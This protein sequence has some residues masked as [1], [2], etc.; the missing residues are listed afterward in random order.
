MNLVTLARAYAAERF[1][2]ADAAFLA[3]SVAAGR[4]TA[5]SDLGLVVVQ[6]SCEAET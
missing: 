1:P 5:S 4:A 2:T 3:G 6:E